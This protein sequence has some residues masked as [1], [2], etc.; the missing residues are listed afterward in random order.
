MGYVR[1][2]WCGLVPSLA[3]WLLMAFLLRF[4]TRVRPLNVIFVG[5]RAILQ[6]TVLCVVTVWSAGN[7]GISSGIVQYVCVGFKGLWIVLILFLWVMSRDPPLVHRPRARGRH[8]WFSLVSR[9]LPLWPISLMALLVRSLPLLMCAI[10]SWMS[11]PASPSWLMFRLM[12]L[13][14]PLQARLVFRL[15]LLNLVLSPKFQIYL[16]LLIL[17]LVMFLVIMIV[18][19]LLVKRKL[20]VV[21]M[22]VILVNIVL[23]IVVSF[24]IL[25]LLKRIL[26]KVM[27]W[28]I[29]VLLK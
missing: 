11:L 24:Q 6:K 21:V 28:I 26:V 2:G 14:L 29:Q 27:L 9:L 23:R 22:K 16:C 7:P 8:L 12:A 19:F 1:L 18:W 17:L 25:V 13:F 4:H 5:S 3:I 20:Q 10:T 15:A